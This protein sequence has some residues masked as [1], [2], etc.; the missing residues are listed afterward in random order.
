MTMCSFTFSLVSMALQASQ[1]RAYMV[2]DNSGDEGE[3]EGEGEE[4]LEPQSLMDQHKANLKKKSK[5]E[6]KEERRRK[7]DEE[8]AA[9]EERLR[10]VWKMLCVC[11]T[12]S[13]L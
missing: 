6:L 12:Y 8:E 7:A 9:R 4:E 13:Q 5:K 2:D 3:G 10:K 1:H 11:S